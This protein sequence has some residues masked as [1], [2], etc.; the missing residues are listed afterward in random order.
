MNAVSTTSGYADIGQIYSLSTKKPY[1]LEVILLPA[2][3]I[4]QMI[5]LYL[6]PGDKK[7]TQ[8]AAYM[9]RLNQQFIY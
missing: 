8:H 4:N 3:M 6:A 2:Q 5:H 9:R 1:Y 7:S